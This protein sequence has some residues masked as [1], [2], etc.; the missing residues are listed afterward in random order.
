MELMA[1]LASASSR[2]CSLGIMGD[3]PDVLTSLFDTN[4][5]IEVTWATTYDVVV[6]FWKTKVT[7]KVQ[8]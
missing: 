8:Y 5:G 1:W 4:D 2:P 6:A 3:P 7:R